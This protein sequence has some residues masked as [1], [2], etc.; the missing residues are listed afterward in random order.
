MAISFY[1]WMKPDYQEKTTDLSQVTDKHYH[2]MLYRVHLVINGV[3][4]HNLGTDCTGSYKSN[5]HTMTTTTVPEVMYMKKGMNRIVLLTEGWIA[6]KT[7][8]MI[9]RS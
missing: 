4:T 7:E 2:I 5:Y 3:R 1:W 6:T 9:G 8:D